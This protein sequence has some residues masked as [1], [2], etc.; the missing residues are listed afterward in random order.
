VRRCSPSAR[1]SPGRGPPTAGAIKA[2]SPSWV[3]DQGEHT[4]FL[5]SFSNLEDTPVTAEPGGTVRMRVESAPGAPT[6][7]APADGAGAYRASL[8]GTVDLA[9]P[10]GSARARAVPV[11]VMPIH[12]PGMWRAPGGSGDW[13]SLGDARPGRPASIGRVPIHADRD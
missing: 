11:P 13:R 7:S 12:R 10:A 6:V 8:V 4:A 2:Q 1:P 5:G 9:R 3:D